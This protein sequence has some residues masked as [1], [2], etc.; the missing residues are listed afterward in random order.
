MAFLVGFG[1]C[2]LLFCW[3]RNLVS[4]FK[5]DTKNNAKVN[6][7]FDVTTLV[8]QS[9]KSSESEYDIRKTFGVGVEF[10][11]VGMESKSEIRDP[12]ISDRHRA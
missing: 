6:C 11:G 1:V 7:D 3:S 8:Y 5:I 10:V 12:L 9:L 4:N 2:F